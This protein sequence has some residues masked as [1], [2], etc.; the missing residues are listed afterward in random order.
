MKTKSSFLLIT[1]VA[2]LVTVSCKT[3][4]TTVQSSIQTSTTQITTSSPD[5]S[6]PWR[7]VYASGDPSSFMLPGNLVVGLDFSRQISGT[8]RDEF[9]SKAAITDGSKKQYTAL[10][11]MT[12]GSMSITKDGKTLEFG[13][14]I[15]FAFSV[16]KGV[17]SYSFK[18]AEWQPV[19]MGNPFSKPIYSP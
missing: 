4:N 17:P 15:F 8:E 3:A 16:D 14:C 18:L 1:L 13:P 19:D 2:L 5:V 7:V 9:K 12:C 6:R 10:A 11:A